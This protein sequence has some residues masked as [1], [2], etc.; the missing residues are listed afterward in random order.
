MLQKKQPRSKKPN[1]SSE[2]SESIAH[3]TAAFLKAGGKVEIIER[4][5]SGYELTGGRKQINYAQK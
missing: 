5:V 2:T 3:Q 4:G 1:A